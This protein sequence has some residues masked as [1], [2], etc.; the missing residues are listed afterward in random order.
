MQSID[1]LIKKVEFVTS[2]SRWRSRTIQYRALFQFTRPG[3]CVSQTEGEISDFHGMIIVEMRG[4][5]QQQKL[6]PGLRNTWL[7]L[8]HTWLG[9][10]HAWLG[11]RASNGLHSSIV[12][13]DPPEAPHE[14]YFLVRHIYGKTFAE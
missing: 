4:E 9:L 5:P 14:N 1:I 7:G 12:S 10:R 2:S 8:Q 13:P 3:L 11:H 6:E